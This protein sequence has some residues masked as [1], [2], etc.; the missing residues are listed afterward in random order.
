MNDRGIVQSD[1]KSGLGSGGRSGITTT[2]AG[3][4]RNIFTILRPTRKHFTGHSWGW[5]I[6][7]LGVGKGESGE[8][9]EKVGVLE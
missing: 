6:K 4:D 1:W 7:N 3:E 8:C 9:S 5:R 2:M